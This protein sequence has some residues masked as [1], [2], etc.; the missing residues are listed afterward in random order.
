MMKVEYINPFVESVCDLF[1][2]MLAAKVTRGTVEMADSGGQGQSSEITGLIG[3]SGPARGTLALALPESTAMAL[4][5]RLL[6]IEYTTMEDDVLDAVSEILNIIAG[7]AKAKLSESQG[8]GTIDLSLPTV[9]CGARYDVQY[10]SQTNWIEVPFTSDLG[11]FGIRV[12]FEVIEQK[13]A[14]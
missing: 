8:L 4:A 9:I 3:W 1:S 2:T 13:A 12:T 7:G 10:P 6:G 14:V 5:S 11:S